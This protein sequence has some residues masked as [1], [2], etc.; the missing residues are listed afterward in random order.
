MRLPISSRVQQALNR[1]YSLIPYNTR[2]RI[3]ITWE[4]SPMLS[5][6]ISLQRVVTWSGDSVIRLYTGH[7]HSDPRLGYVILITRLSCFLLSRRKAGTHFKMARQFPSESITNHHLYAHVFHNLCNRNKIKLPSKLP[8]W[9]TRTTRAHFSHKADQIRRA[10][11]CAGARQL[12]VICC[13][14]PQ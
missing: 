9:A 8:P 5:T 1:N 10:H 2:N 13:V 14:V 7:I 12:I 11:L 3:S 4:L 6:I